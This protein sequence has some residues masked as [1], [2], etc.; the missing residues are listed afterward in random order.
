MKIS[1]RQI[2]K[3]VMNEI[4]GKNKKPNVLDI[5]IN[6][7][8]REQ[9]E[10]L[11]EGMFSSALKTAATNLVPGGR[12]MSDYAQ[13]RGFD[14]LEGAVEEFDRR[15]ENIEERLAALESVATI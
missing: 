7:I 10:E 9:K 1:K 13:A 4:S 12:W 5:D 3:I 2:R 15:L 8:L 6:Y 11:G 14:D